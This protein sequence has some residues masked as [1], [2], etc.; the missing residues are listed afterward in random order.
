[1]KKLAV[2]ELSDALW[3][4]IEPFIPKRERDPKKVYKRKPGGGNK[5]LPYR[6]VFAGILFVL[7]TG[8]QWKAIPT[9]L[10]GG[11]S[12]L[13]QYFLEWTRKGLFRELWKAGL[14]EYDTLKGIDWSWVNIDG[15]MVKAP[16]ARDAVGD[17]PTDRG[18]KRNQAPCPHRWARRSALRGPY[19]SQPA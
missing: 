8:I 9:E 16:L 18:K 4:K 5:P 2:W 13:N 14:L 10:F 15:A 7:R 19:R 11:P 17:N 6:Q 3:E 12:S 1:M